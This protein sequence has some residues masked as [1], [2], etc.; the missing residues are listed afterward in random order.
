MT[1]VSCNICW[2]ADDMS[3]YL[4]I[5]SSYLD[6]SFPNSIG[7]NLHPSTSRHNNTRGVANAGW[8]NLYPKAAVGMG[9]STHQR[10]N[11]SLHTT[12]RSVPFIKVRC[13]GMCQ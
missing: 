9:L 11:C 6:S 2:K 3:Y 7:A 13:Q 8:T 10:L 5:I 12:Y 1:R 4:L